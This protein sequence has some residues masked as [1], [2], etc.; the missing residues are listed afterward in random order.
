M[1]ETVTMT[2]NDANRLVTYNGQKVR[3]DEKGNMTYGPV[4]G[5][6]QELTYDCRN[7]LVEASGVSYTYDAENTR[8]AMTENGLTTEYVTD[9][10]GS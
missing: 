7:R 5:I 8:I 4:D 1:L 2:Y 3:Y 6:M 9:T 10:G